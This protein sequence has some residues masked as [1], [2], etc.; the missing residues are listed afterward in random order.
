MSLR[1]LGANKARCRKIMR[2]RDGGSYESVFTNT[3][4]FKFDK[5]AKKDEDAYKLLLLKVDEYNVYEPNTWVIP[6]GEIEDTDPTIEEAVKQ[7]VLEHTG[8]EVEHIVSFIKPFLVSKGGIT[9]SGAETQEA[10]VELRL[11]YFCTVFEYRLNLDPE[12]FSEGGYF[13]R[14]MVKHLDMSETTRLTVDRAFEW[15]ATTD[16]A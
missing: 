12:E 8:M 7:Q 1:V 10:A 11:G 15:W 2:R 13:D 6:G 9:A 16:S 14:T 4:I 3:I 5:T